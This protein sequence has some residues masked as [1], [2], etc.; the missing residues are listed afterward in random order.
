M[1]SEL[2]KMKGRCRK[3]RDCICKLGVEKTEEAQ[4]LLIFASY[5]NYLNI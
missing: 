4:L 5:G 3:W 1:K 2:L